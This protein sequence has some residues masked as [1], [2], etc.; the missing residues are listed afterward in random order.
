MNHIVYLIFMWIVAVVM[1]LV[2]IHAMRTTKPMWTGIGSVKTEK[3]VANVKAYNKAHGKIWI[4]FSIFLF[5]AGCIELF[6]PA[7][8]VIIFAVF[9]IV[10]IG[11]TVWWYQK[12]NE[13]YGIRSSE[14]D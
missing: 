9:C 4:T 1:F 13:T 12:I 10:G 7:Y 2:G 3:E 6:L 5:L 14:E 8:G 11:V